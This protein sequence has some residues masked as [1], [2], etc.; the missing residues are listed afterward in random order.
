MQ[1]K[2]KRPRDWVIVAL[3]VL[4][5]A[6]GVIT[7]LRQDGQA[8][9]Y[10]QGLRSYIKAQSENA[11]DP[12]SE[13]KTPADRTKALQEAA[14]MFDLSIKV[15]KRESQGSWLQR[16][17]LPHADAHLAALASFR[18][19]NCL[20]WLQK[21]KEAVAAYE[22]YLQLNPGG[23]ND[24]NVGDTLVD[25]HNLEILFNHDPD[26]QEA[27]GKGKANAKQQRKQQN[28]DS[29]AGHSPHTKM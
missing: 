25:Q 24:K 6:T 3:G 17:F 19:G 15:Y 16:F 20:L 13:I 5:L 2:I 21:E 23:E 28:P 7:C 4:I 14:Q 8:I 22:G 11:D 29:N 1:L 10:D 12:A 9:L 27:Q 18:L 26:L